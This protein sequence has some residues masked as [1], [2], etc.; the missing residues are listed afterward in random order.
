MFR[1]PCIVGA[2]SDPE[3]LLG[4]FDASVGNGLVVFRCVRMRSLRMVG[5]TI[6]EFVWRQNQ[7]HGTLIGESSSGPF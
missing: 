3:V 4:V 2:R 1:L 6:S 7:T 5:R